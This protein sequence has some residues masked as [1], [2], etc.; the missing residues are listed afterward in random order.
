M[1]EMQ[2]S[3]G[4]LK[5]LALVKMIKGQSAEARVFLNVLR[6]DLVWSRWAEKYLK[7]LATDPDLADDKEIQQTRRMMIARDDVVFTNRYLPNGDITFNLNVYL[8]KLLEHNRQN[9]MAFEYLVAMYLVTGNVAAVVDSFSFLDGFSY[10][11]I[12]PLCEEA[13]LIYG[14]QHRDDLKVTNSGVFFRGRKISEP[15]MNKFRRFQ[16]I[17]TACGGPNEKAKS[18]VASEL[19]DSY[20]YY[21][22]YALQRRS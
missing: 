3:G 5:R 8:L 17:V 21:F 4:A 16:A 13:A 11:T 19:G 14:S 9:R 20:F 10:P 2:P 6:D 12:P 22:F 1:Q 15:T 18:T 7:L